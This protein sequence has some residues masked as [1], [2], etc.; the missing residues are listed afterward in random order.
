MGKKNLKTLPDKR[1]EQ[2]TKPR[3][4]VMVSP[5]IFPTWFGVLLN[6]NVSLRNGLKVQKYGHSQPKQTA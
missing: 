4:M 6:H 1:L 2:G 5:E 3:V